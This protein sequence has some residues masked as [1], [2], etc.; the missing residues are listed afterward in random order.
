MRCC[1]SWP[2][3]VT[4]LLRVRVRLWVMSGQ[5]GFGLVRLRNCRA[6]DLL[7]DDICFMYAYAACS[8]CTTCTFSFI[9]HL[10]ARCETPYP[11]RP[12]DIP[13]LHPLCMANPIAY[14]NYPTEFIVA[15]YCNQN[16]YCGSGDSL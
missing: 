2:R 5:C 13:Q 7:G 12:L 9:P 14:L 16:E 11:P 6:Y 10:Y 4:L 1:V 8:Q 15:L 3:Y